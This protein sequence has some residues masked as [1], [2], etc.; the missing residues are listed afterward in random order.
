MRGRRTTKRNSTSL[1]PNLIERM[2]GEP[3]GNNESEARSLLAK[4]LDALRVAVN[5]ADPSGAAEMRLAAAVEELGHFT[6]AGA[7]TMDSMVAYGNGGY[8]MQ[9][10]R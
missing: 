5:E 2:Q 10:A 8:T 4:L 7:R 1:S 3:S 9:S 6:L